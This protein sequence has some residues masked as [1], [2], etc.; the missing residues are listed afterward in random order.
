MEMIAG[1]DEDPQVILA[2]AGPDPYHIRMLLEVFLELPT[3]DLIAA[4]EPDE[5]VVL[6]VTERVV[7]EERLE[8]VD[9]PRIQEPIDTVVHLL[10][11]RAGQAAD[12]RVAHPAMADKDVEYL[13]V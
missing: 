7:A 3:S 8:L 10:R 12:L 1:D 11:G 5:E 9:D 4:L 2:D 6:Q 13:L